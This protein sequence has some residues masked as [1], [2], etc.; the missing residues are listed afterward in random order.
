MCGD[1]ECCRK[2]S[3]DPSKKEDAAGYWGTFNGKDIVNC[4]IP[5]RLVDATMKEINN[6]FGN[7]IEFA[8]LTGDLVTHDD[9]A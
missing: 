5:L 8:V 1:F 3:G 2:I 7:E 6:K 9:W 4:D